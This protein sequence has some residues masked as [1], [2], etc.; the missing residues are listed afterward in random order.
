MTRHEITLKI[1][2]PDYIDTL[3]VALARQGHAPYITQD[4]DAVCITVD[5]DEMNELKY[6]EE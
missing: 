5:E 6:R 4:C 2:D 1:L 3:V